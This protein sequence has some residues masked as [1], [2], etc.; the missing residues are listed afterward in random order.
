MTEP[1]T[2]KIDSLL[3]QMVED[4]KFSGTVLVHKNGN[5]ILEKAYGLA[6]KRFNVP[7]TIETK[8]NIGSLNKL[9]TKIAILQLLQKG[10]LNLED[11][12]GKYLPDYPKEIASK[13]KVRHLLSFKS[14]LGD[15][16]NEKFPKVIGQLRKLDDFV[17]LFIDDP[18]LFEPGE[19]QHY[20][21]AGYVVLGKIIEAITGTEYYDYV[22]ENIYKPAKM[23]DSDHFELDF[24]TPNLAT[25]YTRFT[26]CDQDGIVQLEN[27]RNNFYVIGTKGSPAGGGY[28][29]VRDMMRF[30]QAIDNETFLDS[31]HSKMV[32]RPLDADSESKPK[33]AILAGGAP[34]LCALYF[35]FFEMGYT[36]FILSNYDPEDVEPIVGPIRT[37]FLPDEDEGRI[38]TLRKDK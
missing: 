2:K 24:P 18:L 19:K 35:K 11:Y 6:C 27:R 29:T 32:M 36:V 34:G 4:D 16:F 25:G 38:V 8:F 31:K 3:Q 22:R 13:V 1:D 30:D 14:G 9:I 12:V 23:Y 33:S 10:R 37:L 20:S 5:V 17:E 26:Q 21:N 7:N 28:S 15:Y